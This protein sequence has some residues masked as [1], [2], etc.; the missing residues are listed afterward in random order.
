M[1]IIYD[2]PNYPADPNYR[3]LPK[4]MDP[5]GNPN[6]NRNILFVVLNAIDKGLVPTPNYKGVGK[7]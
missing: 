5:S 6:D 7:P 1:D 4:V 3:M 2:D